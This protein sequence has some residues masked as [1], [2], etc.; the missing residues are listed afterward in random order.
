MD[1]VAQ[2]QAEALS[3]GFNNV[4]NYGAYPPVGTKMEVALA[5]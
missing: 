4:F 5:S 1:T 2:V 3:L